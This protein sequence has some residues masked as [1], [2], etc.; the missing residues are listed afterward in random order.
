MLCA[1]SITS[2]ITQSAIFNTGLSQSRLSLQ[3]KVNLML[4][5]LFKDRVS[6][7]IGTNKHAVIKGVFAPAP[8]FRKQVYWQGEHRTIGQ[9]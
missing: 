2:T 1:P 3:S 4:C 8:C 6:G 7:V 9:V 5:L